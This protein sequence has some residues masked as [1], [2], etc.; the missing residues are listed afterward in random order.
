MLFHNFYIFNVIIQRMENWS[1]SLVRNSHCFAK[2]YNPNLMKHGVDKSLQVSH[3]LTVGLWACPG[4][5]APSILRL[6]IAFDQTCLAWFALTDYNT[7]GKRTHQNNIIWQY[8][9]VY[10]TP[11][12]GWSNK[13][14]EIQLLKHP[15]NIGIHMHPTGTIHNVSQPF[16]TYH[17]TTLQCSACFESTLKPTVSHQVDLWCLSGWRSRSRHCWRSTREC[18]HANLPKCN[19]IISWMIKSC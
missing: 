8:D 17:N 11:W 3:S 2:K 9:M 12:F 13:A 6:L 1:G 10:E 19:L 14:Y 5:A 16:T 15:Q 18:R 7:I 4:H